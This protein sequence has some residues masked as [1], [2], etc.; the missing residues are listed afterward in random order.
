MSHA[1]FPIKFTEPDLRAHVV[2]FVGGTAAA[3][4]VFGK[5]MTVTYI[6]TGI[7]EI[8]WPN[9]AATPGAWIGPAGECFEATTQADV[10]NFKAVVG[11]YNAST[12][13]LRVHLF[14]SGS[15]ADLAALEW[16]TLVLLFKESNS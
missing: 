10:K 9:A 3:T 6:S 1:E 11:V 2:K 7:V 13:K 8:A 14:E 16:L 15:L 5:G 12:R 4:K